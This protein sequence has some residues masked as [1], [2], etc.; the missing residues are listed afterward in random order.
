MD[1]CCD[2]PAPKRGE[3]LHYFLESDA[4]RNL[5]SEVIFS[6]L[7]RYNCFAGCEV[8]YT[9]KHFKQALPNFDKHIPRSIDENLEKQW[10]E[11]FDH[12]VTVSSIDDIFWMKHNHPHLYEWYLKHDH[13]FSWGNMTDNNFI[14]TQPLFMNELSAETEIYEITFS[15]D[16]LK[17]VKIDE[18]ISMLSA[19][20]KRLPIKKIKLIFNSANSLENKNVER[21]YNWTQENGIYTPVH[22]NFKLEH[23]IFDNGI[24]QMEHI[25]N[26]DEDIFPVCRESDYLQYDGFFLTLIDSIDTERQ[27]Y[28]QFSQFDRDKHIA[29]MLQGKLD[30]YKRWSNLYKAGKVGNGESGKPY[31]EYYDWVSNNIVVNQDYNFIPISLLD[32]RNRYYHKLK[33]NGWIATQYG[34]LKENTSAVKPILEVKNG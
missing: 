1:K 11:I 18:I 8:C 34:L 14:R 6:L 3:F 4:I 22:N 19:L 9:E 17:K 33:D 13:I 2:T 21:L 27:P 24:P 23:E 32:A 12:F 15:E 20:Y 5:H 31:F 29:Q 10:Y 16:F 28:S 25:V 30:L 26:Y 7:G